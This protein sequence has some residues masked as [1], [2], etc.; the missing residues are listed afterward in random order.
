MPTGLDDTEAEPADN[1]C[2]L[3]CETLFFTHDARGPQELSPVKR[4]LRIEPGEAF[5]WST[6]GGAELDLMLLRGG[7]RWGVELKFGAPPRPTKSMRVALDDLRLQ[8]LVVVYP[9][10]TDYA[11]DDQIEVL[12]LPSVEKLAGSLR[13]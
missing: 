8:R 7:R 3:V 9:G 10:E 1:A 4:V 12:A 6:H 13:G 5:Y 11:L 2:N